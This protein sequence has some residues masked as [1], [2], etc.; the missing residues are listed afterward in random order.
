MPQHSTLT[1][2]EKDPAEQ[3][4]IS[5]IKDL[6]EVQI[7][8]VDTDDVWFFRF[9]CDKPFLPDP[10]DVIRF[11][12][13]FEEQPLGY[14]GVGADPI[15]VHGGYVCHGNITA[16]YKVGESKIS[17][18]LQHGGVKALYARAR[19]SAPSS[20]TS[21]VS[22]ALVGS[23]IKYMFTCEVRKPSVGKGIW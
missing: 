9:I 15:S 22:K 21:L 16:M 3:K 20:F 6:K 12:V 18:M 13:I 2:A 8:S 10:T 1:V 19:N 11:N 14:F 7:V 4:I 5:M 23:G 17:Q